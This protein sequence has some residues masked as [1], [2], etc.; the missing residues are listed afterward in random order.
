MLLLM[1]VFSDGVV[2]C[3]GPTGSGAT[4][5][6]TVCYA[7]VLGWYVAGH[8]LCYFDCECLSVDVGV[9]VHVSFV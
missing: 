2:T 5:S 9:I 4:G 8:A 1:I 7:V 6:F 3:T